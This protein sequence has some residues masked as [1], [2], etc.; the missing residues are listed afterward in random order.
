MSCFGLTYFSL[1]YAFNSTEHNWQPKIKVSHSI[2]LHLFFQLIF[3]IEIGESA[4]ALF[5]FS[6]ESIVKNFSNKFGIRVP[7]SILNE[8]FHHP[9]IA[10]YIFFFRFCFNQSSLQL[11][12]KKMP[13]TSQ[14][15][16]ESLH[17]M[18]QSVSIDELRLRSNSI[19]KTK[20][21]S[22][23]SVDDPVAIESNFLW[24]TGKRLSRVSVSDFDSCIT[25]PD[26]VYGYKRESSHR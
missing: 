2:H 8:E 5:Q 25:A 9:F 17:P 7:V 14:D 13:E 21:R 24:P 26:S 12:K 3:F 1:N 6:C 16:F 22:T 18:K 10:P 23:L 11:V 15:V 20:L 4:L 19:G